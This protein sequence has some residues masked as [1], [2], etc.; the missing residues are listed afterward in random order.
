MKNFEC[1]QLALK[2]VRLVRPLI[3]EIE[4]RDRDL[5]SQLRRSVAS[6]PLNTAEGSEGRG[7]N[8]AAR[9]ADAR[10]STR[11]VVATLEVAEA[12]GYLDA[13][14]IVAPVDVFDHVARIL[15]KLGR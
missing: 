15:V 2:G 3:S 14:R 9:Y 10:G 5:A 6:V 1:Y 12:L 7:R 11:E 4:K 8:R 13:E